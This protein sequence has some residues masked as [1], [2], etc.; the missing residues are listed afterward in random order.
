MPTLRIVTRWMLAAAMVFIGALHFIAPKPFIAIV[1]RALPAPRALVLISG[2][3]EILGGLGLLV[4]RVR[5][6]AGIGLIALY[7]AV[8]PA[9]ITM[10]VRNMPIGGKHRPALLWLRLPFQPVLMAMAWWCS[11]DE[12]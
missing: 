9:N 6:A 10:A 11:Q 1:P 12:E 3:F 8:F 5:R 7:A 4:P 2:F